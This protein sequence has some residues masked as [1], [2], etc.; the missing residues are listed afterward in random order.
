MSGIGDRPGGEMVVIG[1]TID[2]GRERCERGRQRRG[3][4]HH[5]FGGG[6][7]RGDDGG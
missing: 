2:I 5:W 1:Q 7:T 6:H 3:E 4:Y